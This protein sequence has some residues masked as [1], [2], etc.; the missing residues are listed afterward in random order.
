MRE[1]IPPKY[2]PSH[3]KGLCLSTTVWVQGT[4]ACSQQPF[5]ESSLGR[6]VSQVAP[7]GPL[8]PTTLCTGSTSPLAPTAQLPAHGK[9]A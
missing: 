7:N 8:G 4:R 9:N 5:L 1:I 2:K 6:V 3:S